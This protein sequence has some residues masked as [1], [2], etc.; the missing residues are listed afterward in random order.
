MSGKQPQNEP[1]EMLVF[2]TNA[3]DSPRMKAVLDFALANGLTDP[4]QL[5]TQSPEMKTGVDLAAAI[6]IR[7]STLANNFAPSINVESIFVDAVLLALLDRTSQSNW[8][9][10]AE[11]LYK[12][13]AAGIQI[14]REEVGALLAQE[15]TYA[16]NRSKGDLMRS[17]PLAVLLYCGHFQARLC[18]STF[19]MTAP[20]GETTVN[21]QFPSEPMDRILSALNTYVKEAVGP[22]NENRFLAFVAFLE[23]STFPQDPASTKYHL[24]EPGGLALHTSNVLY[25]M[26]AILSPVTSTQMAKIT[27]AAVCHDLCKVGVYKPTVKSQKIDGKWVEVN[28]YSFEDPMPFG[29]GRKSM[30]MAAGYFGKALG[31]DVAKAIDGH[32]ADSPNVESQFADFP[33]GVAL[34][35]ADVIA[36]YILEK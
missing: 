20:D 13:R 24:A 6:Y 19:K 31:E 10:G 3:A 26:T 27:L 34:H 22:E 18:G 9:F 30:Y 4:V 15:G 25:V 16:T 2:L 14:S 35:I 11:L 5:P 33:L 21:V 23:Q 12:V 29:H 7:A 32:M 36:T 8:S 17:T 28:S 1:S